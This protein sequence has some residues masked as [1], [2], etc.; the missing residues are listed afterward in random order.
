MVA[1][2]EK[3]EQN[4]IYGFLEREIIIWNKKAL[5]VQNYLMCLFN[6]EV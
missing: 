4:Y 6:N 2:E 5:V 3:E 1:G